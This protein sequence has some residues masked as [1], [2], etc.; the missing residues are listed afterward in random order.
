MEKKDMEITKDNVDTTVK[1]ITFFV[2]YGKDD[3][4]LFDENH[5]E[6]NK[7]RISIENV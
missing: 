7:I 2:N 5:N 6:I 1:S 3:I 4:V